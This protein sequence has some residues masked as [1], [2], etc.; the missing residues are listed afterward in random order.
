MKASITD[1]CHRHFVKFVSVFDHGLLPFFAAQIISVHVG[2][3][4]VSHKRYEHHAAEIF[5]V[6]FL[7]R[8]TSDAQKALGTRHTADRYD[9]PP[10]RF[11]LLLEG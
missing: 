11:E 1:R 2:P 4:P 8:F 5:L 9:E 7:R 10:A 3:S 6:E